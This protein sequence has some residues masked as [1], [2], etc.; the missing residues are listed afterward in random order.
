MKM[1]K[2]FLVVLLAAATMFLVAC[3]GGEATYDPS[4]VAAEAE[5]GNEPSPERTPEIVQEPTPAEPT[6]AEPTPWEPPVIVLGPEFDPLPG[7]ILF[8]TS[9]EEGL[10]GM[11]GRGNASAERIGHVSR[12]GDYAVQVTGRTAAW[13]G[14]FI[15]V[16]EHAQPFDKYEISVWVMA[17]DEALDIQLTAQFWEEGVGYTWRN[18][19][20]PRSRGRAH[21]GMWI[22]FTGTF[23]FYNFDSVHVIIQTDYP[24]AESSFYMDD[25]RFRDVTPVLNFDPTIRPLHEIHADYFIIG[26]ATGPIDLTGQRRQAH[27][28]HFAAFSAGNDLKPAHIQPQRGVFTFDLADAMVQMAVEEDAIKVGHTLAWHAQSPG[29]MNPPGIDRDL[30]IE[31]LEEHIYA[32]VTRYS[33]YIAIWDVVNEAFPSSVPFSTAQHWRAHLRRT[34]W[35]DAIGYEYIEIAFRAAHRADPYATLIY[36]DYNLDQP[37]K[38]EAVFHM[39]QELLENGVP[40][41]A[42]GM[43]GHYSLSTSLPNVEASIRRFAELGIPVHFTELD[44]T[45]QDALGQTSMTHEQELRQAIFYARLFNIFLRNHEHIDRVTFWGLDDAHSWR[46]DR[47]PLLFNADLTPK[48][49]FW[50]VADPVGF[51]EEH[52]IE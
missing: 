38:R 7:P 30:A 29:W 46:A 12:T 28:H 44:V 48:L 14:A 35:L 24:Y 9:F 10:D 21:P 15:E 39:A 43:Q 26:S 42:I 27:G 16:T 32:L 25:L 18:F 52:G 19:A 23:A 6:P 47:F 37:G 40:I 8:E 33:A 17:M 36:N 49:S 11:M 50:A 4:Y 41:H 13:H 45:V 2:R 1:K 20:G 31:H 34:P 22:E 3:G 5:Q 51:L